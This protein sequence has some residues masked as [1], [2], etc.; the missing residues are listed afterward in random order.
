MDVHDTTVL[1]LTEEIDHTICSKAKKVM[2]LCSLHER[3][4]VILQE[5]GESAAEKPNE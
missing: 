3:L 1:C 5:L 4:L 2:A